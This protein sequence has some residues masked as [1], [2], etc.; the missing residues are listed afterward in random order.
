MA[1][2][3]LSEKERLQPSLLDRLTDRS[4][5]EV[6]ESARERVIDIR[7]L[8]D[9]IQRDL[10]WLLNTADNSANIDPEDYPHAARSTLNYGIQD[11]A[12]KLASKAGIKTLE[13]TVKAAIYAM[14]PRIIPGSLDVRTGQEAGGPESQVA[15]DIRA[16]LWA[17]P[18]PMELYLRTHLDMADGSIQIDK[19]R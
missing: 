9:I 3:E 18:V 11:I 19:V 5:G 16:A 4:P 2:V 13:S 15:I 17:S 14:E 8:R 12:G 6:K 10:A 1:R 7:R